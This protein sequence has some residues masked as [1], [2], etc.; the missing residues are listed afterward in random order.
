MRPTQIRDLT[1]KKF[2]II[3]PSMLLLLNT[4]FAQNCNAVANMSVDYTEDCKAI[5]TWDMPSITSS[6]ILWDNTAGMTNMGYLSSRWMLEDDGRIIIADDF[7]IPS[8]VTWTIE[9]VTFRGFYQT[10]YGGVPPH[11][12]GIEIYTNN[13]NKPGTKSMKNLI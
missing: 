12:I 4:A 8:G 11:Y 13:G 1:M 7:D 6:E 5:I 10:G 9:E 3:L 2:F